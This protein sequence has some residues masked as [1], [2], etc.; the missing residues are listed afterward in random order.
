LVGI[1]DRDDVKG[2]V[3]FSAFNK[4]A[5]NGA[6]YSDA[7]EPVQTADVAGSISFSKV[8]IQASK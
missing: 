5:F 2:S 6:K 7:N 3:S 4:E 1:F 8:T